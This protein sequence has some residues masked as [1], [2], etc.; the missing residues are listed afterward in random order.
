MRI[1]MFA[2]SLLVLECSLVMLYGAIVKDSPLYCT[3]YHYVSDMWV[4]AYSDP[5]NL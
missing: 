2:L 3:G 5:D 1:A 4:V